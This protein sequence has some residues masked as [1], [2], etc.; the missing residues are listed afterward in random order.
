MTLD[1]S[2]VKKHPV[3]AGVI[4]FVGGIIVYLL[5]KHGSAAPAA[6]GDMSGAA[7]QLAAV[8]AAQDATNAQYNAQIQVASIGGQVATAQ[9]NAQ[10]AAVQAETLAAQNIV[11]TQTQGATNIAKITADS[12]TQQTQINADAKVQVAQTVINGQLAAV[13]TQIAAQS[14]AQQRSFDIANKVITSAGTDKSRSS[15]GWAQIIAALQGQGPQAIAANQP[16][17][18]ANSVPNIIG[19]IGSVISH[20]F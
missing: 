20:F 17:N 5:F 16:S 8:S 3:A 4:V 2:L 11:T 9:T 18:V 14:A 13:Q 15:T 19:S 1:L 10:L 7:G 12:T 6:S